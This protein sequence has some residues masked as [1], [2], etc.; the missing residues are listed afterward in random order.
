MIV[1]NIFFVKLIKFKPNEDVLFGKNDVG[2]ID[3]VNSGLNMLGL[4]LKK[5]LYNYMYGMG[6]DLPISF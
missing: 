1:V 4:D 3:S 5:A 2:F 6:F